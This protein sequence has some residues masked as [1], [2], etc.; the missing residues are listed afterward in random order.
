MPVKIRLQRRGKKR[1][2]FYHI[3][4]ADGRAPRDGKYIER[5]GTYNPVTKPA[6]IDINFDRALEWLQMG[7]QPTNTVRAILSYK[8]VLMMDHLQKGVKKG[9]MTQEQ[10]EAKFKQWMEEKEG[11]IADATSKAKNETIEERN[12]R[13][14]KEKEVNEARAQE[15]RKRKED[16]EAKKREAEKAQEAENAE[17]ATEEPAA[18]EA[19]EEAKEE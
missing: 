13:L 2:A 14:A 11:R 19:Q 12:A 1:R 9:A 7:A 17:E 16:E 15:L 18:E 4:I 10:A 3:V 6:T 5:L 8:G